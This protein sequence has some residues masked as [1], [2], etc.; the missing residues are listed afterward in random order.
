[1]LVKRKK[2]FVSRFYWFEIIKG[3]RPG[4]RVVSEGALLLKPILVRAIPPGAPLSPK[5][6]TTPHPTRGEGKKP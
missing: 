4:D 1:M 3:L 2:S 6:P 5:G